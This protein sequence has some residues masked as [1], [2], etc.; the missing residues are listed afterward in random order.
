[1]ESHCHLSVL[2]IKKLAFLGQPKAS[3]VFINQYSSS[4]INSVLKLW[5]GNI[6]SLIRW[7]RKCSL[8]GAAKQ[9]FAFS[10]SAKESQPQAPNQVLNIR[11]IGV[12]YHWFSSSKIFCIEI[13]IKIKCQEGTEH[14]GY[15]LNYFVLTTRLL[16]LI[17]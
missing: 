14:K 1:M 2:I 3:F 13:K 9:P 8:Q 16:S 12:I 6:Q 11:L 4:I 7:Q 10:H 5:H 15:N 17:R